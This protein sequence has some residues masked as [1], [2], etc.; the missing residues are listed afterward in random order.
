MTAVFI[1]GLLI[2]LAG[3]GHC[4]G[5]CGGL[6]ALLSVNGKPSLTRLLAYNFGR[7]SS[8]GLLALIIATAI[9]G[10]AEYLYRDL[11]IPL[12]TIA[13][14]LLILMGLYLWGA[15]QL[16]LKVEKLGTGAWRAL[17]P[18]AK[19]LLPIRSTPHAYLAGMIW[20]WLPCGLVYSTVLWASAL[21]SVSQTSS[22]MIG[23]ALGTLPSMLL[24]GFFA[25]QLK[26]LWQH[27]R[28]G[29]LFG[30]LMVLYGLYTIP[31]IHGLLSTHG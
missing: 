12:R 18:I 15:S 29:K 3:A 31:M 20:G 24:A 1:S 11:M 14:V 6:S 17:Q 27:Y 4:L 7:I 16:I 30:T 10:T 9:Q 13:G 19:S 5:M 23:F 25:Q 21:G 8:Y 26:Q 22:A 28:L 2:G